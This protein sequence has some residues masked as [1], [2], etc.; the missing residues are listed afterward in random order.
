MFNMLFLLLDKSRYFRRIVRNLARLRFFGYRTLFTAKHS[1]HEAGSTTN[2]LGA[3]LKLILGKLV[4]VIFIA[5]LLQITNSFFVNLVT[6]MG[7]TYPK[8][9]DTYYGTLLATFT[10]V[11]GIFIGF[12]YAAISSVCGA[13]YAKVP[14]NM[15]D[16]LAQ[17]PVGNAYMRFLAVLTSFG[18]CM[19]T[20]HALGFEPV[21]LAILLLPLFAG[22]MIIGFVRLG[23]RA[24]HLFDPTTLS[25]AIFKQ[26]KQCYTQMQAGGY[27]WSDESFQNHAHKI[28]QRDIDALVTLADI[29]AKEPHLNGRPFADLSKALLSFL[30]DYE[31]T[32]KLIPTNSLWYEK[33]YEF[34]DWYRTGDTETSIAHETAA[35]PP[36]KDVSHPRWIESTLLP[37]VYRCLAINIKEKRY[38]VVNAILGHLE[39]YCQRLAEEQQVESAFDLVS[40]LFANCRPLLFVEENNVV[41]DEPLEN[42]GICERLGSIL[43]NVLLAY[44]RAI[45]SGGRDAIRRRIQH[46]SWKS[47]KSIYKAEF[48]A[49]VLEQ[50]EWLYPRLQFEEK[51]E[52]RLLSPPSY[53]QELIALKEAENHCAAMV[54]FF[55]YVC[56]LFEAW[57]KTEGSLNHPWLVAAMI[58]REAEYW[59][60]I[61]HHKDALNQLWNDLS[62]HRQIEGLQWPSLNT[63]DLEKVKGQRIKTLLNLMAQENILLSMISRK[64][65]YPDYAGKFL[66]TIGEALLIAMYKNECDT[67]EAIFKHYLTGS[68][69]QFDRL[70]SEGNPSTRDFELAMKVAVAPLLDL[71][72]ISGY[73]YLLADYHQTPRLQEL[74][75][76]AWNEYLN[77]DSTQPRLMSLAG[78]VVISESALEIAHRATIRAGWKQFIRGRLRDLERRE[79]SIGSSFYSSTET[80][81]IHPSPLV[82]IFARDDFSSFYDGID[83]FIAKIRSSE[84][85]REKFGLRQVTPQRYRRCY[86][87]REKSLCDG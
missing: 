18:V 51:A 32:K 69:L 22:L 84:G 21:L 66:H 20:F 45:E 2:T 7:I 50:L 49:H 47:E 29:T 28:A 33:R 64:E 58:A 52:G 26:L 34:S 75:V 43:V 40:D 56:K 9:N 17:E 37:I 86:K 30:C 53:I 23:M 35:L 62:S 25:Y 65:S 57:T 72:D 63:D 73:A 31:V 19:L 13:I 5:V 54:C 82:R 8:E 10:S 12:Y 85:R 38:S 83:I 68:L 1:V 61:D 27:R 44:T 24:F 46:I 15:R 74:I 42:L 77:E 3:L 48:Q 4:L 67:V 76:H 11:G 36:P 14:N 60:K 39:A 6:R 80:I 87:K 55:K 41:I 81:V 78:A 71:M 16:L 70:R 59:N 79:F